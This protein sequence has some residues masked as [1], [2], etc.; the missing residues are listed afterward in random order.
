MSR[1]LGAVCE[2]VDSIEDLIPAPGC[3]LMR[4]TND[5]HWLAPQKKLVV[6]S[7][8]QETCTPD[9][10]TLFV[11]QRVRNGKDA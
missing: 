3:I 2:Q 7:A 6:K 8:K 1:M 10:V 9:S 11:K 4:V 5:S